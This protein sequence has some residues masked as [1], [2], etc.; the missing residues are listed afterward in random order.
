MENSLFKMLAATL[1]AALVSA[2]VHAAPTAAAEENAPNIMDELNPFDPNIES[3]LKKLDKAQEEATGMPSNINEGHGLPLGLGK[4]LPEAMMLSRG[5]CYQISC[6]VWAQVNKTSQSIYIYVNGVYAAGYHV[7]TGIPGLDTPD[8]DTHPD[9]RVYDKYTSTKFPEG[10]YKG[11]GNMPYAVFISGG[12]AIHG[13][14]M[15]NVPK[16]GKPAS[17]GCIRVH[18]DVGYYFNRLV[19]QAGARNTWITVQ[20]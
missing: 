20:P 12:F 19:R 1:A 9:G 10:D 2:T 5:S 3:I 6:A 16:L 11:L 13:T 18:P 17:H 14:T 4:G 7:S 8:F 15:G